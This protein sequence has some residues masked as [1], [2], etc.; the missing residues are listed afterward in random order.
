MKNLIKLLAL[1]GCVAFTA[2]TASANSITLTDVS[3][4]AGAFTYSVSGT[5]SSLNAGDFWTINDF[6]PATLGANT[7]PAGWVF[8]QAL[9]GPNSLPATDNPGILNATFTWTG[10][11]GTPFGGP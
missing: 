6:G 11:N 5:N 1:A 8:S 10:A 9:T 3:Q 2:V 4:V 7:L